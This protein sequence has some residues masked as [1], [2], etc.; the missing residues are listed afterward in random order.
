MN[1]KVKIAIWI[2]VITGIIAALKYADYRFK[3]RP[4]REIIVNVDINGT[5]QLIEEDEIFALIQQGHDSIQDQKVGQIDL[6]LI[7]TLIKTNPY[8]YSVNAFINM[9]ASL[10][11]SVEQRQPLLRVFNEKGESYYIDTEG[12]LLPLHPTTTVY[13]PIASGKITGAFL[14]SLKFRRFDTITEDQ[15]RVIPIEEKLFH[16]AAI[17]HEDSLLSE[18]VAQIY[19]ED[20]SHFELIPRIGRQKIIFGDAFDSEEKLLKLK[21]FYSE[22]Y[23]KYDLELYKAF[24]LRFR[25]QVVCVKK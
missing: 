19:A 20:A 1:R 4:L 6:Q 10:E 14:P 12:A 3:N 13:V 16:I 17:I 18:L 23:S 21:Y 25:N 8:V 7:E 2:V 5:Q 22:A 9:D 11:I 15:C 24:D